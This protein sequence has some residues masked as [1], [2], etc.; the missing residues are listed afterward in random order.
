MLT[1]REEGESEN[2]IGEMVALRWEP[3]H[4]TK[5]TSS[6]IP[7]QLASLLVFI[8]SLLYHKNFILVIMVF[9][10]MI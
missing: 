3:T 6:V 4:V 8:L 10:V 2:V 1:M 7:L 5:H 9:F